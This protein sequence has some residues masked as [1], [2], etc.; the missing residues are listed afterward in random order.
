MGNLESRTFGTKGIDGNI[1]YEV[2]LETPLWH[3]N[4]S[5]NFIPQDAMC[6]Y[7]GHYHPID[8]MRIVG[9]SKT[10]M[11]A[12][13]NI[14]GGYIYQKQ[15]QFITYRCSRCN[16]IHSIAMWVHLVIGVLSIW[17]AIQLFQPSSL[18]WE[19]YITPIVIGFIIA[20][21]ITVIDWFFIKIIFKVRRKPKVL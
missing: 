9:E 2:D 6:P 7:C 8:D 18:R 13:A 16:R 10:E 19:T 1:N 5:D 21:I 14:L 15:K 17:G 4:A 12:D 11:G 3:D 20:Y